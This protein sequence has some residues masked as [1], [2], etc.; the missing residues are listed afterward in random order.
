[1]PCSLLLFSHA[2]ACCTVAICCRYFFHL[3]CSLLFVATCCTIAILLLHAIQF[4]ILLPHAVQMLF[5]AAICCLA[6]CGTVAICCCMSYSLLLN[7]V[8]A[9]R[10]VC[11]FVAACRAVC[12]FVAACHAVCYVFVAACRT[13]CY[14]L[15]HAVQFVIC[16]HTL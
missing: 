2:H 14:L 11:Y 9:C 8:A 15:P 3:R 16:C 4:A 10:A 7:F 6:A 12:Y 5:I 1:M 13:V